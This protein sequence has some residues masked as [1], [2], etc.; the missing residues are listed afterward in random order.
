MSNNE[1]ARH[2]L[3]TL[4]TT[5][6][7][8]GV[9]ILLYDTLKLTYDPQIVAI[10]TYT[11]LVVLL[12]EKRIP[13]GPLSRIYR[14]SKYEAVAFLLLLP[15][16]YAIFEVGYTY[17]ISILIEERLLTFLY[18]IMLGMIPTFIYMTVASFYNLVR[19]R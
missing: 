17:S 19:G 10:V 16:S 2:A 7:L 1:R 5:M 11:M 18:S 3:L 6:F 4:G 14:S 8:S 13:L 15:A 12:I 9:T